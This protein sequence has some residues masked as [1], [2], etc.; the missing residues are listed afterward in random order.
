[1]TE[2]KK[3]ALSLLETFGSDLD[4]GGRMKTKHDGHRSM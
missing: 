2:R 3:A 1:M 4:M